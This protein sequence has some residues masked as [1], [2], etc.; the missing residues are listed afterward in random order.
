MPPPSREAARRPSSSHA[1]S[2]ASRPTTPGGR[3]VSTLPLDSASTPADS[4]AAP[5]PDTAAAAGLAAAAAL[6]RPALKVRLCTFNMH[7]STPS[8]DLSDFLGSI[9]R[10]AARACGARA[11]P[12]TNATAATPAIPATAT[13]AT[14]TQPHMG[15]PPQQQV[16]G[17]PRSMSAHSLAT[18]AGGNAPSSAGTGLGVTPESE[19]SDDEDS[20]PNF[21]LAPAHPYHLIAVAGQECPSSTGV[22][23]GRRV[24]QLGGKSWT[25]V[26]EDYLGASPQTANAPRHHHHYF[27]H[28]HHHG[29]GVDADAASISSL[30]VQQSAPA[31]RNKPLPYPAVAQP[32]TL[33]GPR[34]EDA[35]A[36][37]GAAPPVA[38]SDTEPRQRP[39]SADLRDQQ[40]LS[41]QPLREGDTEAM[42]DVDDNAR[43]GGWRDEGEEDID[44][45]EDELDEDDMQGPYVLVDKVRLMGIYCAVFCARSCA[46]LIRGKQAYAT[47]SIFI[48]LVADGSSRSQASPRRACLLGC[49]MAA[50]ATK[51]AS[52]SRST[53]R[54]R[55]CSSSLRTWLPTSLDS[56]CARATYSRSV[57]SWM[58]TTLLATTRSPAR[59]SLT[60]SIR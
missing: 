53:L 26:L 12:A 47:R 40:P 34:P 51:A 60:A 32:E 5:T 14:Q 7:D 58:S 31:D 30:P 4:S 28:H 24:V 35:V 8:G 49:S 21:G 20:V 56:R 37:G 55:V 10:E 15:S 13:P 3:K 57:T 18:T 23:N 19:A 45:E 33:P 22:L 39:I 1:G 44:R 25:R 17:T 9:S 52:A 42:S 43:P 29:K 11:S 38:S 16:P 59:P 27:H 48:D 6:C 41:Q 36:T 2:N 54:A 50:W 46:H